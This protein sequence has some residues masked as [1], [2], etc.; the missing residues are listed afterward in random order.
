MTQSTELFL[1]IRSL[2][3][4]E[5]IYFKKF[6][7]RSGEK[8]SNLYLCLFDEINNCVSNGKYDEIALREKMIKRGI[9]TNFEVTKYYLQKVILR[10]LGAFYA[11]SNLENELNEKIKSIEIL[12]KRTL[13]SNCI[14]KVRSAKTLAYKI[15][16]YMK[17]IEIIKWEKN[18][19][20]EGVMKGNS[21]ER[22]SKLHSEENEALSRIRIHSDLRFLSY[23]VRDMLNQVETGNPDKKKAEF[24]KL[25]KS[26]LLKLSNVQSNISLISMYHVKSII[27]SALNERDK[28]YEYSNNMILLMENSKWMISENPANYIITLYNF[29]SLC[30]AIRKYKE[31]MSNIQKMRSIEKK[32]SKKLS[33][34]LRSLIF[35]GSYNLELSLTIRL[36][37]FK[38]GLLLLPEIEEG[39][40][41]Y[42]HIINKEDLLACYF[43]LS[44]ICFQ[45]GKYEESL[46]WINKILN[47]KSIS[48]EN[49]FFV[50]AMLMNLILHYELQNFNLLEYLIQSTSRF[51][52]KRTKQNKFFEIILQ[53]IRNLSKSGSS[54]DSNLLIQRALVYE[55]PAEK[56]EFRRE[57]YSNFQNWLKKEVTIN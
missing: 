42:S 53:I 7:S 4:S 35:I 39:L 46:K 51:F 40:K 50:S 28:S 24:R 26:P 44:G 19:I 1:L 36:K 6:A 37:D 3:K 27:S 16:N 17:V 56:S 57:I 32:Y 55:E 30:Y 25:E 15:E 20:H 18:L 14:K 11:R 34:N 54:E 48:H 41:K 8:K 22:L 2:S 9:I 31:M 45:S 5:K 12:Y 13:Y 33:G 47:D 38:R 29:V 23:K 43:H 21:I 52:S 10:S 49:E